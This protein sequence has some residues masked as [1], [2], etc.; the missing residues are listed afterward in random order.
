MPF[1]EAARLLAQGAELAEY[2]YVE[3]V[4]VAAVSSTPGFGQAIYWGTRYGVTLPVI[5]HTVN[6]GDKVT[7][8]W[9][10][11]AGSPKLAAF[12]INKGPLTRI[13]E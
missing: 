12:R 6:I 2:G 4:T 3:T 11:K 9:P 5:E 10:S 8:C 7:L 13:E 1:E